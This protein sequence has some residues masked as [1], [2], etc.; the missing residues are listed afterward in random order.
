MQPF[1]RGLPAPTTNRKSVDFLSCARLRLGIGQRPDGMF[2]FKEKN[3][4]SQ[5]QKGP[6]Y[7]L[8]LRNQ[9]SWISSTLPF[10]MS[11]SEMTT[12]SAA[13]SSS[14]KGPYSSS[15][16]PTNLGTAWRKR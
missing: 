4:K 3:K 13:M 16:F 10:L 6:G 1:W 5:P 12:G 9:F 15:S 2:E 8:I 11:I 7:E 14:S